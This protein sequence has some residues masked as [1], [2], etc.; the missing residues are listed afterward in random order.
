M[1]WYHVL[2][3]AARI[4]GWMAPSLSVSPRFGMTSDGSSSMRTPRPVHS[5]QA[6]CGLLKLKLRGAISPMLKP[7]VVQAKCSE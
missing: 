7:Q 6:P 2:V 4:Q 5:G 3:A 1:R